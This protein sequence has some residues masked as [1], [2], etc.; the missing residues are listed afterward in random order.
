MIA[1]DVAKVIRYSQGYDIDIK[2]MNI[3]PL[4]EQWQEAKRDFIE[5]FD[6]KYRIEVPGITT[7]ELDDHS[8][9][10]KYSDFF[11]W[12]VRMTYNYSDKE[13]TALFDFMRERTYQEFF[14]NKLEK[15]YRDIKAGTKFTK[16]I[17]YFLRPE[18][19][20]DIQ[21]KMS[22]FIQESKISG[23][24]CVSVH[25]LDYLSSSENSCNWRSCHSL[26]GDFRAGNLAYMTDTSTVVCYLKSNAPDG[27]I[28]NFPVDVPWNNKKWRCLLFL[29]SNWKT[30]FAGRQYPFSTTT[31][32]DVIKEK[33]FPIFKFHNNWSSWCDNRLEEFNG[34][35][36][37][38]PYYEI[39]GKLYS[40]RDM[41]SPGSGLF[42]NDLICS[43]C[44]SPSYTYD[45]L[46]FSGCDKAPY[47]DIGGKPKCPVCGTDRIVDSE[48][49]L[50]SDCGFT[51][52]EHHNDDGF[53]CEE[54]GC[55]VHNSDVVICEGSYICPE[56]ADSATSIC[57]ICG[58]RIWNENGTWT[59]DEEFVCISHIN[60]FREE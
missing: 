24:L 25:P 15:D 18:N 36:L 31:A 1:E 12:L 47:F 17:K 22:M 55:W 2:D 43:H 52:E 33:I 8:K 54:C 38:D 9:R 26:D 7:F 29:D 37:K 48:S 46:F 3:T 4:I 10:I 5:A 58:E 39:R 6:G 28:N 16:A 45:R 32:L 53:Y 20:E 44:Y 35:S 14:N 41:V 13:R 27:I 49:M 51:Y 23:I 56:C 11:E 21:I 40:I 57:D 30:V 59:K 34:A 19:V 50:C 42:F 60:N